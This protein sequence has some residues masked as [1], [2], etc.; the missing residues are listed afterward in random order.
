[1]RV[2]KRAK[3]GF[4]AD[5]ML[6]KLGRFLRIA[7]YDVLI[8]Q[9][10]PDRRLAVMSRE[11]NSILLTRDKD[12]SNTN[13]AMAF[14]ILSDELGKQ[15]E[16]MRVNGLFD[17]VERTETRC[18]LCGEVLKKMEKGSQPFNEISDNIPE[19]VIYHHD[20]FFSCRGCKKI[21]WHGRQW[22]DILKVLDGH[23]LSPRA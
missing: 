22:E 17:D 18:P 4:I 21:Y 6:Q 19:K 8:P 23:G 15:L 10:V 3:N 13:E 14:R 7:G 9:G 16:E 1:M 11:L 5:E 2:E 12:L 20:T